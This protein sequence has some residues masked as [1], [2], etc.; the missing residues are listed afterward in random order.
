MRRTI[1]GQSFDRVEELLKF[2]KSIYSPP[3][4]IAQ[5][6]EDFGNEYQ[7]DDENVI[8]FANKVKDL[9]NRILESYLLG[10]GT[11]IDFFQKR[12]EI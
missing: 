2:L 6:L 11:V 1:S 8:T 7:N 4:N 3:R 9:S 5:F 10:Q 12:T